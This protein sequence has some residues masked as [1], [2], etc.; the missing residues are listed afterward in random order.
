MQFDHFGSSLVI[1]IDAPCLSVWVLF[2]Q[3]KHC[4]R[5]A[6]LAGLK[7]EEQTQGS[8]PNTSKCVNISVVTLFAFC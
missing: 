6:L 4:S 3:D 1:I 2:L 5:E 8:N 7:L